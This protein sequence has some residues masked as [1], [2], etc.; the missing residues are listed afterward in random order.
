[1]AVYSAGIATSIRL[2]TNVSGFSAEAYALMILAGFG[3]VVEN[4]ISG[5]LSDRYTPQEKMGH[6]TASAY[7]YYVI[8]HFLPFLPINGQQPC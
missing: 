3:M 4:L 6:H 8:A 7:L 1:M 5:R 2:F